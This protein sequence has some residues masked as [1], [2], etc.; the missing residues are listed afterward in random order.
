MTN[1]PALNIQCQDDNHVDEEDVQHD[2]DLGDIFLPRQE[3]L[4]EW[5][6]HRISTEFLVSRDNNKLD[7]IGIWLRSYKDIVS[8]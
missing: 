6:R 4:V 3:E 2:D 1:L 5:L 7:H 8:S